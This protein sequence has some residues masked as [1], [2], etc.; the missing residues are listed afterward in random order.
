MTRSKLRAMNSVGIRRLA[1]TSL[2]IKINK[3]LDALALTQ[4]TVTIRA[5]VS[6]NNLPSAVRPREQRFSLQPQR[7]NVPAN[8]VR[9]CFWPGHGRSGTALV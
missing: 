6:L 2:K 3:S 8:L 1:K 4:R 7:A 5:R 9:V